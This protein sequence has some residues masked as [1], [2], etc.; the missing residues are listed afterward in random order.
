MI[1]Q[2]DVPYTKEEVK[3][4]VKTIHDLRE[5]V[6]QLERHSANDVP[7]FPNGKEELD[8]EQ[9]AYYQYGDDEGYTPFVEGCKYGYSYAKK[10]LGWHSA[11][12]FPIVPENHNWISVIAIVCD[13]DDNSTIATDAKFNKDKG[14]IFPEFSKV[15]YWCYPPK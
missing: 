8:F 14:W 13:M 3:A 11:N 2:E 9:E 1:V 7:E 10:Q 5:K 12:N 6:A 4:M 15:L